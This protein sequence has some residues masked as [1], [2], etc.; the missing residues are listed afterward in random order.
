MSSPALDEPLRESA[1]LARRLAPSLCAIDP[2]T[3]ERCDWQ[4]GLWQTLRL[5]GLITTPVHHAEFYRGAFAAVCDGARVLV[6]GTADYAMLAQVIAA[7]RE[8]RRPPDITVLDICA[9]AAELNRWYAQRAGVAVSVLRSDVL[10]F[11]PSAPF[12]AI[13]THSF[14]GQFDPESRRTLVGKWRDWLAP[15]GRLVT[16]NRVRPGAATERIGFSAEQARTFLA[17]VLEQARPRA[18]ELGLDLVALERDAARY[19]AHQGAWPLRSLD[20]MR[21]LFE[22]AGFAVERLD[23]A[24]VAGAHGGVSGPTTPG[25]ARYAH[26]VALRK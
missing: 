8:R 21:E 1:P 12:D 24:P 11:S 20:E 17:N 7:F 6:S 16:I 14:I 2:R 13:C 22:G 10:A 26:I 19:A 25:N 4:H 9:T 3:G 23:T 15:G 5:L 18:G